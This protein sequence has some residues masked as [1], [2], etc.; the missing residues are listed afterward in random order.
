MGQYDDVREKLEREELE[1]RLEGLTLVDA[2][3]KGVKE[4]RPKG[5]DVTPTLRDKFAM[6]AMTGLTGGTMAA[7]NS[8]R[9]LADL[10]YVIADAMMKA[11][12]YDE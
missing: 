5:W 10:S 2:Y 8:A 7:D 12:K 1:R 3:R 4:G 6:S 9:V 11:R